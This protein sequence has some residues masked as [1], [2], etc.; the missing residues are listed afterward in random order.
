MIIPSI[1]LMGGQTVQLIGGKEKA[2]DAGDPTPIA[3]SFG[4]VGEIAVIDLDAAM[5]Q[6]SN[7]DL[8]HQ[9]LGEARCRVGGG[10]RDVETAK[11]WLNAGA[12]KVILGT[13]AVPEVLK[14]LPSER[15]IAAL[16]A[17]HGEVVVEGWKQ[18]TGHTVFARMKELRPYVDGFLVTF[19]EREGQMTGLDFEAVQA[20]KDAAEGAQLTVAGGVATPQEVGKLDAMG[21]D[22]QVGMALYTGTFDLADATAACLTSDRPDGLWPTVITDQ[23]GVALGMAYSD[24]ESL[25]VALKEGVGAY[26]SRKR[27][28]WVKGKSSGATQALLQVDMDCDRDTLRFKVSQ[29]APGFCHEQTWSCWGP[30]GGLPALDRT[31]AQRR[32]EAPEGSYTQR[33]FNDPALLHAKILEEAQELTEAKSPEEVCHES[34]DVIYFAMVA[35]ARAGLSLEDIAKEL[36]RRSLKV[37]RRPGNAKS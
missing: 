2:I 14:E 27:G 23:H 31:L 32:E 15:V 4:R 25:K 17:V 24:L 3:Q 20:L 33:L 29:Q 8:I 16:D 35:M 10:I 13:A 1:D 18:K 37:T 36:D 30:T 28:L 12:V 5:R 19:V 26:H 7:A 6:G 11:R 21:I 34:A 9:V 22:A